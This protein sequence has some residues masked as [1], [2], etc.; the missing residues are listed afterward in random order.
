MYLAQPLA[1]GKNDSLNYSKVIKQKIFLTW[2]KQ[3]V[4]GGPC[5]KVDLEKGE[6]SILVAQ[7]A[8]KGLQ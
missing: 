5:P 6:R 4:F 2:T 3:A 8:R 1:H 7:R